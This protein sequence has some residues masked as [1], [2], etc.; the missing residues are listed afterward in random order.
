MR[1]TCH[2]DYALRVLIYLNAH[3][4]RLCSISEISRAYWVSHNHMMKVVNALVRAGF[5]TTFRGRTG[6]VRLSRPAPEISIGS[7]VRAMEDGF[8]LVKCV[9]CVIAPGCGLTGLRE[10]ARAAFLAVLDS[11]SLAE[12][13]EGG[14]DLLSLWDSCTPAG[15]ASSRSA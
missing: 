12:L 5:V 10:Q 6:G 7:V 13:P 15:A 8:E 1:F 3:P 9:D 4:E 2:T 11:C 14:G